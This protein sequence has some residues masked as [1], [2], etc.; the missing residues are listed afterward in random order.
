MTS[1]SHAQTYP[2]G[3]PCWVET[4]QPDARA[5][6]AFYHEVFGWD[7]GG[8]GPMPG[9]GEYFVARIDGADVAGIGTLPPGGIAEPQWATYVLVDDVESA[10]SR[11]TVEAL[12]HVHRRRISNIMAAARANRVRGDAVTGRPRPVAYFGVSLG[13]GVGFGFGVGRGRGGNV[14]TTG[15]GVGASTAGGRGA[16]V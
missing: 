7:A 5:A 13:S 6:A 9:G 8:S 11:A 2:P 14:R 4:L 16:S 1:Q 12:R 15:R 3:A 10:L